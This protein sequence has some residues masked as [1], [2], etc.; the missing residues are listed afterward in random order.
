MGDLASSKAIFTLTQQTP[1]DFGVVP[2]LL[3]ETDKG[4]NTGSMRN[5]HL[6]NVRCAQELVVD[7]PAGSVCARPAPVTSTARRSTPVRRR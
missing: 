3:G 7:E 1:Y 2:Q 5:I 6:P 4:F